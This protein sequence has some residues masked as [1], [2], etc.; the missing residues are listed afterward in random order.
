MSGSG[1]GGGYGYQTD[2][3]AFVSAYALAE[4]PLNWFEDVEDVP[5]AVSMETGGPGD[6]LGVELRSGGQIE[7]QCKHGAKKDQQFTDAFLRAARGLDSD[8][9]LRAVLMVDSS[10]SGTIKDDLRSDIVR[11]GMG[12]TDNL[13]PISSEFL[14]LLEQNGIASNAALFNRLRIIVKDLENGMDGQAA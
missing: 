11:L 7:I 1:G 9:N 10:S 8:P 14:E 4:H 3:F 5:V 13:K 12:R 6:D 2:A